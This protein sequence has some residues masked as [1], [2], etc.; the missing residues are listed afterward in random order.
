MQKQES[1]MCSEI[2]FVLGKNGGHMPSSLG[3]RLIVV[4]RL[5][6]KQAGRWVGELAGGQAG[7]H[8]TCNLQNFKI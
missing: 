7:R 8:N 3:G 1:F 4:V 5:A 2:N 6:G